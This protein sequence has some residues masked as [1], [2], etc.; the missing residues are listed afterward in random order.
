MK[1]LEPREK[2]ALTAL[3][4]AV[5]LTAVVLIY[6]FWP[7][8]STVVADSSPQSVAQMEQRLARVRQIAAAVPAKQEILKKVAADLETRE[9][10]LIRAET[11]QQAQAQLITILR[12]L[13]AS[14]A[15][16]IEI[17]A[18]E[19][20]PIASF[21]DNYGAVNVSI[22]VECRIEQL[23][24]LLADLAARPELIATRDLRVAAGDPKQKTLNVHL[25][26]AGIVPKNLVPQKKGG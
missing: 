15:P 5:G 8:S 25:T 21:G 9:K 11:A 17:R 14:E 19:L 10:G 2:K 4:V 16:P 12:G 6:Q 20:G 24:N 3:A 23:L 26:V 13:G 1:T 18:T 22:Q 7:A